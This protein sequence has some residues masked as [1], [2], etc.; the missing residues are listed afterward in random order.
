MV[1]AEAADADRRAAAMPNVKYFNFMSIRFR[2]VCRGLGF[3]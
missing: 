2:F 3:A 1:E